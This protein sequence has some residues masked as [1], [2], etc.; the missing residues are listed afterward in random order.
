VCIEALFSFLDT[1]SFMRIV[2]NRTVVLFTSLLLA[3][4]GRGAD[5]A[6]GKDGANGLTAL[7]SG[8]A[9]AAG[10]HCA[11]GGSRVEAG[12]DVNGNGV[13]DA[14]EV[15]STQYV[16]NGE[17]G[18]TGNTGATGTAT[19][20]AMADEQAGANC[21]NGGK[22]IN[23]GPDSNGNGTLD[24]G[25]IASRVYVCNGAE[26]SKGTSGAKG[27]N[28]LLEMAA[29]PAGANCPHGGRKITSGL[30]ANASGVLDAGEVTA[31]SYLCQGAPAG[32]PWVEVTGTAAQAQPNTGYSA[33]N[34]SSQVV[35]TLPASPVLGDIVRVDGLGAGGWKIAQNAGQSINARN[36]GATAGVTW[37]AHASNQNWQS[38]ASSADGVKLVAAVM[39]GQISTSTDSGATWIARESG[40]DWS[41]VASSADGTKLAATV[42]SGPIYTSTDSGATWTVRATNQGW[43]AV[44]SSADGSKLAAGACQGQIFTSTDSGASWTARGPSQNWSSVASSADGSKLVATVFNG[45]I[46]TSTD[47]GL[48]WTARA[49]K[50][51]WNAVTSSADGSKLAAT[52]FPG[53]IY[54]STDSGVTWT[55]RASRVNWRSV[56]SSAD[57]AKLIAVVDPGQIYTST[58]SG[59]TWTARDSARTWWSA[60]SSADGSRLVAVERG[61]LIYTSS[62]WTTTG[63]TGGLSGQ[64][65]DAIELHYAGGG[66][67]NI[68]S[69]AGTG[70]TEQY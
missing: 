65:F 68:L 67:F 47:S 20:V 56:A 61:G 36:L 31:T 55:P 40:R 3:A 38:V 69:Y 16:C 66:E 59:V 50:A 54:T 44:A 34:D 30:D 51:I 35:I 28:S 70:I 27:I 6:N 24:A 8:G 17:S 4:C 64:Q 60:A 25:E 1:E 63:P 45:Q 48:T 58:D 52:Q 41:S 46:Y 9:E 2:S 37:T 33:N 21:A 39:Y 11:N 57:G 53:N 49:S 23:V 43:C 19:L 26:G 7:I 10:A 18:P 15:S 32:L 13:L 62:T 22:A 29:E 42:A 12:L 5:G 14:A